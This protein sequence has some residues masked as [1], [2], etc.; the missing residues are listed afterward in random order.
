MS[1]VYGKGKN[2]FYK[3]I[4]NIESDI[5]DFNVKDYVEIDFTK[6]GLN[7]KLDDDEIFFIETNDED[8]EPYLNRILNSTSC[9][10]AKG[11]DLKSIETFYFFEKDQANS[12][13]KLYI[14]RV[15]PSQRIEKKSLLWF[16]LGNKISIEEEISIPILPKPDVYWEQKQKKI[17]FAKFINLE[18]I[19]P[20]FLKYYRD[21]NED[22][23]KN[24]TNTEKY[25]FL[26][27]A[28]DIELSKINKSKLKTLALIVDK[29]E[30]ITNEDAN[31]YLE[32]AKKYNPNLIKDGKFKIH[33]IKDIDNFSNIIFEKF[34]TAE[35]GGKEVRIANSYKICVDKKAK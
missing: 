15:M 28:E 11:E 26:D 10:M 27:I 25:P 34:F 6:D 9:N 20:H 16:K 23:W 1:S 4:E 18:K 8:I 13:I 7:Y 2:G 24:F 33:E 35:V 5:W 31:K 29:L 22:D 12:D 14:Q 3:L 21:A 17:Y 30:S 32:Y 19:F